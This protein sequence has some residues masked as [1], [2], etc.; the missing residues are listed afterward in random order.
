EDNAKQI[1]ANFLRQI[2]SYN[3]NR[4][5]VVQGIRLFVSDA[6][7]LSDAD[8]LAVFDHVTAPP[9][10]E[11]QAEQND[12]MSDIASGYPAGQGVAAA[13]APSA[14]AAAAAP[15]AAAAGSLDGFSGGSLG[16]FNAP[17]GASVGAANVDVFDEHSET[18]T[19]AAIRAANEIAG[20]VQREEV[21]DLNPDHLQDPAA[22]V[23]DEDGPSVVAPAV[24]VESSGDESTEEEKEES[25]STAKKRN[26]ATMS[27]GSGGKKADGDKKPAAN[28]SLKSGGSSKKK[29]GGKK[30][31]GDKNTTA[32]PTPKNNSGKKKD[33]DD[34]NDRKPAA[35][36]SKK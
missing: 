34:G 8:I 19:S 31:D 36:P 1:V 12:N 14:A 26:F 28:P 30:A 11:I 2:E 4:A 7:P 5:T 24:G 29:R 9:V 15:S 17:E 18:T 23:Q 22:V 21:S 33:D 3:L 35:K 16:T 32:D 6:S 27:E 13:A 25:R 20:G 10:G